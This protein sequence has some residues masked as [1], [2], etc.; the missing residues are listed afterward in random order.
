[1]VKVN[2]QEKRAYIHYEK[3]SVGSRV[4]ERWITVTL[5]EKKKLGFLTYYKASG[6]WNGRG[7]TGRTNN[8]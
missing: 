7:N 8:R 3:Y 4:I 2:G 1:M 6:C 5:S